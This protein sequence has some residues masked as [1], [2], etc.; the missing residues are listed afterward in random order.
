[1][2]Q[3]RDLNAPPSRMLADV[4]ADM[5]AQERQSKT[6][7]AGVKDLGESGDIVWP[8]WDGGENSVR[9]VSANVDAARESIQE[10][11]E[12][13]L[14]GLADELEDSRIDL[15]QKLDAANARID[16]IIVDGGGA[17]NFTT[18]S[19][20]PPTSDGAGDGDQWFRVVNGEVIGQWR[21]DGSAWVPVT[22]TD[23]IIAGIDLSKL[24]SN[25]NLSEVVANKMFADLFAAN[26]IT[27]QEL[28][29]G[30]VTAENLAAGAI[31]ADDIVG[32]SFTGE[33]FEGGTFTGGL[34]KTSDAL[35]GKVEF[36]DD[37]YIPSWSATGLTY[38]GLR[39]TPPDTSTTSTPPGIGAYGDG[40]IVD[41][42]KSTT[43]ESSYIVANPRASFMRTFRADGTTGGSIQTSPTAS[44]MRTYQAD[45]TTGGSIQTSPTASYMRTYREDGST[46]G[47]IQTS[48]TASYMRTYQADGTT[49]G[50]IQTSPIDSFMQTYGGDSGRGQIR[51]TPTSAEVRV[52]GSS[53]LNRARITADG[54]TVT[55]FSATNG[56]TYLRLDSE[57][58]SAESGGS[59]V[60]LIP[61]VRP[62]Q[63]SA[64]WNADQSP[65][66]IMVQHLPGG[67]LCQAQIRIQN[68]T[69]SSLSLPNA[70][71]VTLNY[72]PIPSDLRGGFTDYI[73]VTLPQNEARGRVEMN[74]ST[75]SI[76]IRN[77]SGTDINWSNNNSIWFPMRWFSPN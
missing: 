41:G 44:Y 24:V 29:V 36:A 63:Y 34:F 67:K 30:A 71:W 55:L 3:Y 73:E 23:A 75:G 74:Y 57:G 33:T 11:N 35:P 37:G 1:M 77:I 47:E 68:L 2:V 15:Q 28:A 43:G 13:V 46:G 58:I 53:G 59:K 61:Q 18:Y 38:P 48:P 69:G 51:A 32:G 45:G 17:G 10:L 62:F 12:V 72:N 27:A 65:A 42:G 21:W 16:D 19:I 40:V 50:A 31:H 25:G 76:R 56:Q 5:K 22:L 6:G 14:P 20:N 49:G 60:S 7:D 26:K 8:R 4:V 52:I 9:E 66:P 64:Q 54:N 70:T 39:V